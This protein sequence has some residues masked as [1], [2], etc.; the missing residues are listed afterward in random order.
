MAQ[1]IWI[2]PADTLGTIPEGTYY[3]VQLLAAEPVT[4]ETVYYEVI[5]GT[6]PKGMVCSLSGEVSGVP[7]VSTT[8]VSKFAIRAYTRTPGGA[9]DRIADRTFTLIVS[10]D[11]P[12]EFITPAGTVADF[13]TGDYVYE[14]TP[15]GAKDY[16]YQ[17]L[18]TQYDVGTIKLVAGSLPNGTSIDSKGLI[19]GFVLPI[20][21][22]IWLNNYQFTLE[23]S[24]GKFSSLRTFNI[25]IYNRAI[26]TADTTVITAD[27]S[28]VTADASP[29]IPPIITT[30]PG[31]LGT[32]IVGN[33]FSFQFTAFDLQGYPY[34]FIVLDPPP[35]LNPVPPNLTLDPNSGWLY[36][37]IAPIGVSAKTFTFTVAACWTLDPTVI[38]EPVTVSITVVDELL[39]AVDWLYPENLGTIVNGATSTL[40]VAAVAD[41]GK[42][43]YY[44]MAIG[45]YSHLPQGLVLLSNGEISGRVAFQTFCIDG[46]ATTFDVTPVNGISDPTTFD[47]TCVFTVE[48][49]SLDGTIS[50][51]KTFSILVDR[52]YNDPY[53]N[54]FIQAM[55]PRDSRAEIAAILSN[56]TVF[57]PSRIY[58]PTDPFWG[59]AKNVTYWHCYGLNAATLDAY[60]AALRLNHYNKQ[61]VL[62]AIKT[63]RALDDAGNVIYEVIY[64]EVVDNLVNNEGVSIRKATTLGYPASNAA[65]PYTGITVY[66]NSLDNMRNQ[67]IDSLGQESK[68]LPGWMLSTQSD[69]SILGF[70]PAWVIAYANPGQ[71]GRVVYDLEQYLATTGMSLSNINFEADRYEIDRT[72]DAGWDPIT[73]TWTPAPVATT[74]DVATNPPVGTT[75]DQNSMRFIDPVVE[76]S[77]TAEGYYDAYVLFPRANII[78]VPYE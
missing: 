14:I 16:G 58:R 30:L 27:T 8:T 13:Y 66:P 10:G 4:H 6:L 45:Q 3:S 61:L 24:N 63:A 69:G 73:K 60:V 43:L 44:R 46:G 25:E 11:I 28:L 5:S 51:T 21:N 42:Q 9:V 48:A 76:W 18:F 77:Q 57:N 22:L 78:P 17:I 55:P 56:N 39:S 20:S 34:Q 74:F 31:S 40:A 32:T 36:G 68:M 37:R 19:T 23:V 50:V 7:T 72:L 59:V 29:L 41:S 2:T 49:Y 71:S 67:V 53:E 35:F 75:F 70:T 38:G 47:L 65:I 15:S 52:V 33:Y 26:L 12:P 62:G 1:P 64:S 54:L